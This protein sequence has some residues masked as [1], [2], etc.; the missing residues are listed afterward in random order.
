MPKARSPVPYYCCYPARWTPRTERRAEQADHRFDYQTQSSGIRFESG[1]V[2][3]AASEWRT[4]DQNHNDGS[5]PLGRL[6]RWQFQ[7]QELGYSKGSVRSA[8]K[9]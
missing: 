5:L 8:T 3:E 1:V 7:A 6:Q 4:T 2:V 9:T